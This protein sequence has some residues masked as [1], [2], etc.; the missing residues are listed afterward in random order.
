M[1]WLRDH[2]Q[3]SLNGSGRVRQSR[4]GQHSLGNWPRRRYFRAVFSSI[5]AFAAALAVT[6]LVSLATRPPEDVEDS[7]ALLED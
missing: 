3:T 1:S 5:P 6:V 7:F 2:S 4:S